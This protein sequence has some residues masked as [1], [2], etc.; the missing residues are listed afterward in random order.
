MKGNKVLNFVSAGLFAVG[1]L[2]LP[3]A[4]LAGNEENFE[5]PKKDEDEDHK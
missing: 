1:I 3:V 4:S 2:L 5:M